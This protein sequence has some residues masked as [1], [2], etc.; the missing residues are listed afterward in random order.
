PASY[1]EFYTGVAP[2]DA[3]ALKAAILDPT[4][5]YTYVQTGTYV[6]DNPVVINR[7]NS[8]FIHC[9]DRLSARLIAKDPSQPLFKVV[10]APLFNIAGCLLFPAGDYTHTDTRAIV[11]ANTAPIQLEIQD[12]F[13][14]STALEFAGP[15]TYRIQNCQL[16]GGGLVRSPIVIDHPG[17]DVLVFG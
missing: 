10:N 15:G 17:A 2:G 3:A 9:A 5:P 4:K 11:T 16:G 13:L 12:T 8:L 6:L 7:T 1:S 14:D